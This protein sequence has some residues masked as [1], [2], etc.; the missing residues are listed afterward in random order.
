MSEN[1]NFM[2]LTIN[3]SQYMQG[4]SGGGRG[5]GQNWEIKKI[6][7]VVAYHSLVF[8]MYNGV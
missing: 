1:N 6:F 7:L 3:I 2:C 5:R 4:I 8:I